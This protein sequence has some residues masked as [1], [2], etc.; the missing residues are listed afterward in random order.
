V[1]AIASYLGRHREALSGRHTAKR[2]QWYKTIAL[3]IRR[4]VLGVDARIGE[5]LL[6]LLAS[7]RH[8]CPFDIGAACATSRSPA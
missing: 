2:G 3:A 6:E 8:G 7:R 1:A 4:H 5:L